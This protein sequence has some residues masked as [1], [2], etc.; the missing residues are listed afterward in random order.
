MGEHE[1]RHA[2][3]ERRLAD[4]ARA[5]DQ[6]GMR[7]ALTAI[8]VEERL[9]G[10]RMAVERQ[11]PARMRDVGRVH[12]HEAASIGGAA[13]LSR[14]FTAAQTNSATV[15]GSAPALITT[16]RLGSRSASSR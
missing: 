16:Q 11:G 9:L 15:A 7:H 3:G 4:A 12:A 2:V 14:A 8:G 13:G 6:P 10:A 5:A 1:A